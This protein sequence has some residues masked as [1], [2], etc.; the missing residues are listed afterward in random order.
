MKKSYFTPFEI[1]LWTSSAIIILSS[2][3]IWKGGDVLSLIS[4]IVGIT[5]LIFAAKGNPIGP[6]LMVIFSIIYGIISFSFAYYG[7][8]VTYL[9]MTLPMSV[10]ALVA[11]LKNPYKGKKSEVTV[12]KITKKEV[13]FAA[14]LTAAVTIAFYFILKVLGNANL[15]PSTLSVATS[16]AAVYLTY[17]RSPYYAVCYAANDIV[18]IVL[19]TLASLTDTSY[20]SVVVCFAVFLINDIYGFINWRKMAKNQSDTSLL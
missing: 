12:A 16:F 3:F 19:W 7:E 4:S 6:L 9:G 1:I 14:L 2:F 5:S 11:W 17:R 15:V 20:I 10:I 8:M 13:V 18:L